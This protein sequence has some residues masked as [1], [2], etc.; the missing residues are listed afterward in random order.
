[1]KGVVEYVLVAW[2]SVWYTAVCP[3]SVCLHVSDSPISL[4]FTAHYTNTHS[5]TTGAH[6]GES[7]SK[8]LV[9]KLDTF[10]Y[11]SFD[12][13]LCLISPRAALS[14]FIWKR[15]HSVLCSSSQLI[16]PKH[17]ADHAC[18]RDCVCVGMIVHRC[19]CTFTGAVSLCF[20]LISTLIL[21]VLFNSSTLGRRSNGHIPATDSKCPNTT[22]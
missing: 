1:M 5:H 17:A 18:M 14:L 15:R 13:S 19:Y 2:L 20:Q 4:S 12:A 22:Q 9:S 7:D 11:P 21:P 10:Y 3:G 6:R 16:A 8:E